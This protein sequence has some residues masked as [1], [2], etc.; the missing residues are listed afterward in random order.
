MTTDLY[1]AFEE[2]Y[3]GSRDLIKSRLRAY[4][5]FIRPLANIYPGAPT[6]DLGCGRGE[7]LELMSEIG[8]QPTGIDLDAGMLQSCVEQGLAVE[9]GDAIAYLTTLADESQAVVS[10]FHV[11]EHLSFDELRTVVSE[12]LRVLMP[13]GLLLLETP[14]PENIRVATKDFYLDPTHQRPIPPELLSFVP[15]YYGFERVK[16]LRLQESEVLRRNTKISL[17]DVLGG[18][19]PDYAVVAQKSGGANVRAAI[20]PAFEVEY[21]LSFDAVIAMYQRGLEEDAHQTQKRADQTEALARQLDSTLQAVLASRSWKITAPL[22]KVSGLIKPPMKKV[23]RWSVRLLFRA[24]RNTPPLLRLARWT[25]ARSSALRFVAAR[26]V[27]ES[28]AAPVMAPTPKIFEDLKSVQIMDALSELPPSSQ[29]GSVIFL[30]VADDR[31]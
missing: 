14:N 6:A 24:V 4:L 13:G 3:R 12:G 25:L 19:S 18:V 8:F 20:E 29:T 9:H 15:Q 7:W 11:V 31:S 17:R 2:R 27:N 26:L 28:S 16:V 23:I 30:K 10:A 1:R 22:R 5:P 21:G